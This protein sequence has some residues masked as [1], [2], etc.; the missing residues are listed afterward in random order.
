M[1]PHKVSYLSMRA[2]FDENEVTAASAT[3]ADNTQRKRLV[4]RGA[5][6]FVVKRAYWPKSNAPAEWED[7][8]VGPALSKAV[9]AY[10]GLG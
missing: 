5:G 3:T 8:Y 6:V 10:N 2:F 9:A 1:G 4:M 7:V